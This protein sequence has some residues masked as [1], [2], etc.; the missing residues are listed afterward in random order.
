MTDTG[1]TH[2]TAMWIGREVDAKYRILRLIGQGGMGAVYE[3]E[4]L[5]LGKR[6]ALK[7]IDVES[8]TQP[9]AVER[10]EREARMAAAIESANVVQ[11]F[12]VGIAENRPYL[13]M[14]LLRGET[15]GARLQREGTLSV[16]DTVRMAAQVLR[17][18]HRAHEKG[19]V[20]RDLKPENIF[21]ARTDDESWVAKIVDFGICKNTD[22]TG[23][24]GCHTLTQK[25]VI[26]GTPHYM[27]PEQAQGLADLDG[28]ADLWSVGVIMFE[29]LA[30]HRPFSGDNYEQVI[31]AICT[32]SPPSLRGVAGVADPIADVVSR[33][34]R[35]SRDKRFSSAREYLEALR[36]AVPESMQ[37]ELLGAD[38]IRDREV[39]AKENDVLSEQNRLPRSGGGLNR[40][41]RLRS[42]LV[43]LA[44]TVGFVVS[45][46]AWAV[47]NRGPVV[48]TG[49]VG[50]YA[51]AISADAS[52]VIRVETNVQGAS[53]FVGDRQM[54]DGLVDGLRGET[55]E[56]RVQAPGYETQ[57]RTL[58]FEGKQEVIRIE[59]REQPKLQSASSSV[60]PTPSGPR[61]VTTSRPAGVGSGN[62]TGGLELKT[63]LP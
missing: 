2:D 41:R 45:I 22:R 29:C 24:L 47:W 51:P 62:L 61:N 23:A 26:L 6:V 39:N 11:V 34:M 44:V 3:A 33:A 37:G 50:S 49:S 7:I 58:R 5:A 32:Q 60:S 59:L 14:E 20:H 55:V 19:V 12:D 10:F 18:L 21:L 15:L 63:E 42:Y 46:A 35:Q 54:V 31:I 40:K 36:L 57:W 56:I 52:A 27:A 53:V 28:R 38:T 48:G 30:G 9:D 25:G 16:S 13:V 1:S 4:N 8:A 43:G 17:G